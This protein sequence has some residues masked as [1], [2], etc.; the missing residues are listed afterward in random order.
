MGSSLPVS[1]NIARVAELA[2]G[3]GFKILWPKGR[4]GSSPAPGTNLL[5]LKP[6]FS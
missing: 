4:A 2:D 3:G 5:I 6:L 1:I